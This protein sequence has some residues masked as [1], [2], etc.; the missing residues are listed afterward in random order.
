MNI[1]ITETNPT[2]AG[3]G[4]P[5]RHIIKMGTEAVQ[6]LVSALDRHEIDHNVR[7]KAGFR[8][9]GGY[10]HHPCTKWTGDSVANARWV[11]IW[12]MSIV[13]EYKRRYG[14]EHFA[15]GQLLAIG[16]HLTGLPDAEMTPF[17]RAMPDE[18]KYDISIDT[19]TAYR[20]YLIER[21]LWATWKIPEHRPTWWP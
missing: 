8:H 6:M 18:W 9:K 19:I 7:N 4:L 15:Y 5:D 16:K 13:R 1:F 17:V 12:G 21:K 10:R 11:H 14:R 3:I 2:T 20:R